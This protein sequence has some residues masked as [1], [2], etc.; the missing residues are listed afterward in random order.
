MVAPVA[1]HAW[2]AVA[3]EVCDNAVLLDGLDEA[4]IGL[5]EGFNLK[6]GTVAVYS[7]TRLIAALRA[8][9]DWDEAAAEEWYERKILGIGHAGAPVFLL[10]N[11]DPS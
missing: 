9:N 2:R 10:D 11:F 3:D 5:A 7:Y 8:A 6:G 1:G 4:I